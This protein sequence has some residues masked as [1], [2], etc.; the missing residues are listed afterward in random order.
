MSLKV[1]TLFDAIVLA[2]R[3]PASEFERLETD[4]C[5][6]IVATWS[7]ACSTDRYINLKPY[8]DAEDIARKALSDYIQGQQS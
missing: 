4:Y 7:A 8:E 6:A 2:G 1:Y 3:V 5:K